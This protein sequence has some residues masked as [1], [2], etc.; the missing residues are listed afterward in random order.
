MFSILLVNINSLR[1]TSRNII[2]YRLLQG[3]SA[4]KWFTML[5]V[6]SNFTSFSI[7][8]LQFIVSPTECFSPPPN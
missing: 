6:K 1:S 5:A 4:Y 3:T 7:Q 8:R 2:N